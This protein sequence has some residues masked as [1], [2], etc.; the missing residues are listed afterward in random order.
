MCG[1]Y[2]RFLQ[3]LNSETCTIELKNGTQVNGTITG[4]SRSTLPLLLPRM[5]F[6]FPLPAGRRVS[7]FLRL[8]RAYKNTDRRP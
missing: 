3:K 5:H 2:Y 7:G 8:W 4:Q 1:Y 6:H